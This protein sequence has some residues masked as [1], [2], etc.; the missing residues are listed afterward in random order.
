MHQPL[1]LT[2]SSFCVVGKNPEWKNRLPWPTHSTL[3]SLGVCFMAFGAQSPEDRE[4]WLCKFSLAT[5]CQSI[6]WRSSRSDTICTPCLFTLRSRTFP[7]NG[8]LSESRGTYPGWAPAAI[9]DKVRFTGPELSSLTAPLLVEWEN[10]LLQDPWLFTPV[11]WCSSHKLC[12]S[13]FMQYPHWDAFQYSQI[14][15]CANQ[16]NWRI[17]I[18]TIACQWVTLPATWW[19]ATKSS[20]SPLPL[21]SLWGKLRWGGGLHPA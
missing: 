9:N 19:I 2:P 21:G 12:I 1:F 11:S 18:K 15:P 16:Q 8:E 7:L 13:L 5:V 6:L 17:R 10:S 4:E 14:W 3:E 20:L